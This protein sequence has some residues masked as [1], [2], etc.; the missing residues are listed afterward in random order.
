[1]DI[2]IEDRHRTD[3]KISL[4]NLRGHGE[5]VKNT[6]TRSEIVVGMMGSS[7]EVCSDASLNQSPFSRFDRSSRQNQGTL[8]D[9]VFI[10]REDT[11]MVPST[12]LRSRTEHYV[13]QQQTRHNPFSKRKLIHSTH[14][15]PSSIAGIT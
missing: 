1:M 4:R 7:A 11:N 8:H 9:L 14:I 13:T 10:L 12:V 5:I 6:I 2:E 3:L 15:L